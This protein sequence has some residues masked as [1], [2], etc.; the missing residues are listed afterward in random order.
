M[1]SKLTYRATLDDDIPLE[2]ASARQA[3]PNVL[4][5]LGM[6]LMAYPQNTVI[7]EVG[8]LRPLSALSGLN[9][10]R[11]D[12]SANAVKKV[13]N[14]LELAGCAIDYSGRD[15]LDTSRFANIAAYQRGQDTHHD[16]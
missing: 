6:A 9:V 12:G 2:R 16:D 1:A 7:V 10:V 11:F 14:R 4:F 8:R 13:L 5:E 3:R 15:W